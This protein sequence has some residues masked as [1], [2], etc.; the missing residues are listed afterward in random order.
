MTRLFMLLLLAL[1]LFVSAACSS[2][3]VI[4]RP[5]TVA[6][7]VVEVGERTGA[8][9]F[10]GARFTLYNDSPKDI[11]SFT[12]SFL[13]YDGDGLNPFVGTNCVVKDFDTPISANAWADFSVSLD[14]LLPGAPQDTFILDFFYV[15]K[16]SYADGT[17]WADPFGMH[18]TGEGRSDDD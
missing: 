12:V 14:S 3:D 9:D 18:A 1:S 4:G 7:A 8:Y 5:Y 6:D 13:V 10:A 11:S 17:S 15:K 2:M 16:I